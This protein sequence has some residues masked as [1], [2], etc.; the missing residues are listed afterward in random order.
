M[1]LEGEASSSEPSHEM[2]GRGGANLGG[3]CSVWPSSARAKKARKRASKGKA[4]V[5]STG[6]EILGQLLG[7]GR[8]RGLERVGG[9]AEGPESPEWETARAKFFGP[10]LQVHPSGKASFQE[11]N[12]PLLKNNRQGPRPPRLG[13]TANPAGPPSGAV[14]AKPPALFGPGRGRA[15]P[16]RLE[17]EIGFGG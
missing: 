17:S 6:G 3:P 7:E 14:L 5:R 12:A 1:A 9:I 13:G 4:R 11:K 2:E 10:C 16:T 15:S 8:E